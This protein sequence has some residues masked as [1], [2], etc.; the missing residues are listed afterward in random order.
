MVSSH[1]STAQSVWRVEGS[2]VF[3]LFP[4]L[5]LLPAYASGIPRGM[6]KRR[7]FPL[8][9]TALANCCLLFP[10]KALP[11]YK[12]TPPAWAVSGLGACSD[13]GRHL[14][15]STCPTKEGIHPYRFHLPPSGVPWEHTTVFMTDSQRALSNTCLTL[16]IQPSLISSNLPC[17]ENPAVPRLTH[18]PD[19]P[20][21]S[22]GHDSPPSESLGNWEL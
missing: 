10:S 16:K 17:A 22:R 13:S 11:S 15:V 6:W 4:H 5:L 8:N 1:C 20:V 12:N 21:W 18:P 3:A 9:E 2:T 19:F 14:G 7:G